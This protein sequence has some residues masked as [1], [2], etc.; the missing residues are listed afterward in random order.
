M[1]RITV[2]LLI[3]LVFLANPSVFAESP[4]SQQ[5]QEEQLLMQIN[6]YRTSKNLKP[7]VMEATLKGLAYKHS[8]DMA[9]RDKLSHDSSDETTFEQRMEKSGL[10]YTVAVENIAMSNSKDFITKTFELWKSSPGHNSNMLGKG[11]THAGIG[12]AKSTSGA[13][14]ATFDAADVRV[15]QLKVT[16]RESVKLELCPE[17]RKTLLFTYKF[18]GTSKAIVKIDVFYKEKIQPWLSVSPQSITL[19]PGASKSFVVV[20]ITPFAVG[21]FTAIIRLQYG[22]NIEER[23]YEVICKPVALKMACQPTS[24]NI[25]MSVGSKFSFFAIFTNTSKCPTTPRVSASASISGISF[26]FMPLKLNVFPNSKGS[27]KIEMVLKSNLIKTTPI[28]ITLTVMHPGGKLLQKIT[29]FPK[30]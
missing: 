12:F 22:N 26:S 17:E 29:I 14:Y 10:K 24:G 18:T 4:K 28:I 1:K 27:I 15:E 20:I 19:N 13:W 9:L 16:K 2:S 8:N 21:K 7:L 30:K 11:I 23:P 6:N 5:T 3:A 25:K